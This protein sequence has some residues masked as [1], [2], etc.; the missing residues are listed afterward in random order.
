M[1]IKSVTPSSAYTIGEPVCKSGISGDYLCGS[2]VNMNHLENYNGAVGSCIQVHNIDNQP[3][4]V[5][6]DSGGPVFCIANNSAYGIIHG[7]GKPGKPDRNDLFYMPIERLSSL[8][9][10]VLTEPFQITSI[11]DASVPN[12]GTVV[13]VDVNFKGVPRFPVTITLTPVTCPPP[14]ICTESSGVI[15]TNVPSPFVVGLFCD[16]EDLPTT[17]FIIQTTLKDASL[18][19]TPPVQHA[20]KCIASLAPKSGIKRATGRAGAVILDQSQLRN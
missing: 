5:E 6:G 4:S 14:W 13:P 19:Q 2:V 15:T 12:G 20:L 3:V 7:R 1:E 18:I 16:G 17:T 10:S 11:P 8:G 9:V